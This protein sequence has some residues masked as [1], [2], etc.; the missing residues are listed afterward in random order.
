MLELAGES[1]RAF[2]AC[3]QVFSQLGRRLYAS[4]VRSAQM[5]AFR[6]VGSVLVVERNTE[7][8]GYRHLRALSSPPQRHFSLTM[9]MADLAG[10]SAAATKLHAPV[11]L[12]HVDNNKRNGSRRWNPASTLLFFP[13]H[14]P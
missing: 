13:I 8:V 6:G 7:I 4:A 14:P 10:P 12:A 5:N 1:K 2:S 11:T 9:S 3:T